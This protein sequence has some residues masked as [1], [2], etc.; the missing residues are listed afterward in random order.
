MCIA[1]KKK[2]DYIKFDHSSRIL[3]NYI[4]E[5]PTT[6]LSEVIG[7]RSPSVAAIYRLRFLGSLFVLMEGRKEKSDQRLCSP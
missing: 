7:C 5:L 3:P 1:K 4:N 6:P 2:K